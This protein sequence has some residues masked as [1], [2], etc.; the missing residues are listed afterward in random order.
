[1]KTNTKTRA[2]LQ[3]Q[4]LEL[5]AQLTSTYYYASQDIT[6]CGND[7]MM[8]S[9]V[10]LQISALGGREL[11]EPVCIYDGLSQATIDA[12]KADLKRSHD[13]ST[14]FSIK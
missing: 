2:E 7:K 14:E 4:I 12:I 10:I 3:C 11:L 9:G 5:K 6:K 13:I 1:M 8:A